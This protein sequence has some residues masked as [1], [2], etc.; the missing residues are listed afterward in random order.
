MVY[1]LVPP[2]GLCMHALSTYQQRPHQSLIAVALL[3][4]FC[5]VARCSVPLL[6]HIAEPRHACFTVTLQVRC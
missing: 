3:A 6:W 2:L 1:G 4:R 5:L